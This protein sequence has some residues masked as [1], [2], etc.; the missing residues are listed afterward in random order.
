M[1]HPRM[2]LRWL[3]GNNK[4]AEVRRRLRQGVEYGK[5]VFLSTA[6]PKIRQ[7]DNIR[8][9]S[10]AHNGTG[11]RVIMPP[12]PIW[13]NIACFSAPPDQFNMNSGINIDSRSK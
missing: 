6:R 10:V 7:E 8:K 4:A 2:H 1:L 12:M 3:A 11:I 13:K 9:W 5:D